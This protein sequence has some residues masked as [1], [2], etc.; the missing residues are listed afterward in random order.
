[1]PTGTRPLWLDG[2]VAT[3]EGMNRRAPG[4]E[5]LSSNASTM[6]PL[7]TPTADIRTDIDLRR[8]GPISDIASTTAR[9]CQHCLWSGCAIV[10]RAMFD[11]KLRDRA[12]Q[13][14]LCKAFAA[15]TDKKPSPVKRR[16]GSS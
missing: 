6:S 9:H 7:N 1:M 4:H 15:S 16:E 14:F 3:I 11:E 12:E 10:S 5:R 2:L 8:F 13:R